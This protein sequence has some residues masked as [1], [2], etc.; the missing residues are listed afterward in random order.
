MSFSDSCFAPTDIRFVPPLEGFSSWTDTDGEIHVIYAP[1]VP[2]PLP[3]RWQ[4]VHAMPV[5]EAIAIAAAADTGRRMGR[6]ARRTIDLQADARAAHALSSAS[7]VVGAPQRLSK[8]AAQHRAARHP[9]FYA[10]M[11]CGTCGSLISAARPGT[12][13][14]GQVVHDTLS[15]LAI[16]VRPATSN[17]SLADQVAV[18]WL[19][20]RATL[21]EQD[22]LREQLTPV[23]RWPP[24]MQQMQ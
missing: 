17:R 11:P 6:A 10:G 5:A 23:G 9:P 4:H 24:A 12:T 13:S 16:T 19:R 18:E 7:P 8:A 20:A 14:G 1:D 2:M 21:T 22:V 15:C 3:P